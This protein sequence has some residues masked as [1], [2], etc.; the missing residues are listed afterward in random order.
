MKL[1]LSAGI[2]AFVLTPTL[3]GAEA[4]ISRTPVTLR[5]SQAVQA[6]P[7]ENTEKAPLA[8]YKLK[9]K[10]SFTPIPG[11]RPPFWP[12]GWV[13]RKGSAPVELASSGPKFSFDGK[14]FVVTS[15]LLGPPALAVVNGR[16]YEEGQFLRTP[17][18]AGVR[19][20]APRVRVHRIADG[21]IWL[22][23][24]EQIIN[25]ALKRPELSERKP[26]QELL[27]EEQDEELPAPAVSKR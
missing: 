20:S 7:G 12:I 27:N 17:R 16:A 10:S 25:I 9:N 26:E 15:I 18:N 24:E 4:A 11:A 19:S 5:P 1:L 21:Q 14:N 13:K 3:F 6:A 8:R 22:Q 23:C 2:A